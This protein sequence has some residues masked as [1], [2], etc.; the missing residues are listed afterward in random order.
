MSSPSLRYLAIGLAVLSLAIAGCGGDD[1][2]T[3]ATAPAE[4][5]V[6]AP[7]GEELGLPEQG[8]TTL[9]AEQREIMLGALNE[10][11]LEDDTLK[12]GATAEIYRMW[13]EPLDEGECKETLLAGAEAWDGLAAAE[14]SGN[15]AKASEFGDTILSVSGDVD[16]ICVK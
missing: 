16:A 3:S 15:S 13:A 2:D 1:S 11:A 14:E 7:S 8:A 5:T 10:V 4:T 12:N 9:T 6:E